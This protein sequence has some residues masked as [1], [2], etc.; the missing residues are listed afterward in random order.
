MLLW[1][2]LQMARSLYDAI[3]AIPISGKYSYLDPDRSTHA[4]QSVRGNAYGW[5][6]NRIICHEVPPVGGDL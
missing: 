5:M 1:S 3:P 4:Y 6:N 2:K